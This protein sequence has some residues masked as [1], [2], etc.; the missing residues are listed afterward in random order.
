MTLEDAIEKKDML[1][2]AL[3]IYFNIFPHISILL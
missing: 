3:F 2:R 1:S